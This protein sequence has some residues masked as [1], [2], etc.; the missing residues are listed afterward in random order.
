MMHMILKLKLIQSILHI[1]HY[2][3]T[4]IPWREI[5]FI[6]VIV[7]FFCVCVAY[8][9]NG[10]WDD[11]AFDCELFVWTRELATN[12]KEGTQKHRH[13][14]MGNRRYFVILFC[15]SLNDDEHHFM[16]GMT[17]LF[18]LFPFFFR[19]LFFKFWRNLELLYTQDK[20]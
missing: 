13:K 20:T 8:L 9:L 10:F 18:A 7:R 14:R 12:A 4:Q 11:D 3:C 15:C 16:W 5:L 17:I 19:F 1:I 2:C 6:I